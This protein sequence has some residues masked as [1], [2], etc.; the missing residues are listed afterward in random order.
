[1]QSPLSFPLKPEKV[2]ISHAVKTLSDRIMNTESKLL[3]N[4]QDITLF[5]ESRF[6]FE[7]QIMV[8]LKESFLMDTVKYTRICPRLSFSYFLSY[9]VLL[10]SSKY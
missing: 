4:K 6:V 10:D 9:R 8:V 1:M 7:K 2:D 3:P 5:L